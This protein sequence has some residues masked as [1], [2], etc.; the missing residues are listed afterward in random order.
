[1]LGHLQFTTNKQDIAQ[2]ISEEQLGIVLPD[3]LQLTASLQGSLNDMATKARLETS[4]GTIFLEGHFAKKDQ[5]DF[6][7][8]LEVKDL[9]LQKI[10]TNAKLGNTA[11]KLNIKG[12][13]DNLNTLNA[14]LDSDITALELD[15]YDFSNLKL[16]GDIKNGKG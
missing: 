2:F 13:G 11:F 12:N 6:N 4:D 8:Q 16:T 5:L 9:E 14:T 1:K 3:S 7:A 10:V 15:G